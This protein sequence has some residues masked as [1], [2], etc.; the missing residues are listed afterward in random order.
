MSKDKIVIIGASTGGPGHLRK[1]LLSLPK[2]IDYALVIAQH[3]NSNIV[4]SFAMQMQEN[5]SLP[6]LLAKEK[7]NVKASNI[8]ICATSMEFVRLNNQIYLIESQQKNIYSPSVNIL[9]HSATNLFPNIT[10]IAILLTGIGE[11]GAEGL[12]DL[13]VRGAY[14]IAESEESAIV[15][16]MPK[17]AYVLNK[18]LDIMH[19]EKIVEYLQ[20][21]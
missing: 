21:V 4:E 3:M 10:L 20:N 11:D 19:L 12:L 8:Y 2:R 6:V 9:F 14:C 17:Q 13:Y 15:Y 1:I 7:C 16:G 5:S 18:Q